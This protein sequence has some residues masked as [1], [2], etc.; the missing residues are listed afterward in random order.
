MNFHAMRSARRA[1]VLFGAAVVVAACAST[2]SM[3]A[4]IAD[5]ALTNDA[6][7]T[8][9]TFDRDA[10]GS[11][12]SVCAGPCAANWPAFAAASTT[13]ASADWTVVARDDGT[14]QWAYKGRPLYTFAKDAKPGD[15]S[16]DGFLNGAWHGARP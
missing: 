2:A 3:P 4:K 10:T 14:R 5:G 11:G 15:R 1:V 13:G 16:G 7:M 9:Y 8:L 12:K 6:G